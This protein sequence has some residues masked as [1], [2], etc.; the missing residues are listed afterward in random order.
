MVLVGERDRITP[1]EHAR[2]IADELPGAEFVRYPRAGHMLPF[3]RA[4][5]VASQI[6][7]LATG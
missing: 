4:V 6:R 1:P 3:E 5:E 2:I 7:R